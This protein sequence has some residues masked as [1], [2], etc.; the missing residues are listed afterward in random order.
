M[1]EV[2]STG[3]RNDRVGRT[4]PR[5]VRHETQL[6]TASTSTAPQTS[7]GVMMLASRTPEPEPSTELHVTVGTVPTWTRWPKSQSRRVTR[8]PL[9]TRMDARARRHRRFE[10]S[11]S[12]HG[13]VPGS[14]GGMRN[15]EWLCAGRRR[16]GWGQ[17]CVSLNPEAAA[18]VQ[19]WP[20]RRPTLTTG[21]DVASGAYPLLF[22]RTT[23]AHTNG[24][25]NMP[26]RPPRRSSRRRLG[27]SLIATFR[28]N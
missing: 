12:R 27:N 2:M 5:K 18:W 23:M 11:V 13:Q 19:D 15:P 24:Q 21:T 28:R 20:A 1:A 25:A 3:P 17:P 4:G 16:T 7:H 26:T 6:P 14:A 10:G 22:T 9:T 8:T